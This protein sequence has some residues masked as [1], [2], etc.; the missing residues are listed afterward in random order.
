ML[1]EKV[2]CAEFDL[3]YFIFDDENGRKG[4]EVVKTCYDGTVER[5]KVHS[6]AFS[7]QN[8][9]LLAGMLARGK[10]T[11]Y[12]LDDVMMDLKDDDGFLFFEVV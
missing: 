5:A 3:E 6:I 9:R 11:P 7:M 12:G 4:I 1:F 8:A 10:V 2:R